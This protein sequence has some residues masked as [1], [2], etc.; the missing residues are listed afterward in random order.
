MHKLGTY[1]TFYNQNEI[2]NQQIGDAKRQEQWHTSEYHPRPVLMPP[3]PI[4]NYH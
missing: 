1:L 3:N 2:R 4:T